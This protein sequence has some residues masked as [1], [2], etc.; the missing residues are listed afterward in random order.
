MRHP[1]G[2]LSKEPWLA[3]DR[4][5]GADLYIASALRY[6]MLFGSIPKEDVFVEYVAPMHGPPRLPPHRRNLDERFVAQAQKQ[7]AS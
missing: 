1:R 3:G 4:F 7:A 6:G 5:T 2:A